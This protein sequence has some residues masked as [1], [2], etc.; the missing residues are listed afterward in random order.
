MS[1]E[2]YISDPEALYGQLDEPHTDDA[3]V[4]LNGLKKNLGID[5]PQAG[6]REVNNAMSADIK[7][8]K[9]DEKE[10]GRRIV[11]LLR[12][13]PW[14]QPT[15][16]VDRDGDRV[17]SANLDIW[18]GNHLFDDHPNLFGITPREGAAFRGTIQTIAGT[19]EYQQLCEA[20][21]VEFTQ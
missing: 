12:Q 21:G 8:P 17:T 11:G 18:A 2:A 1:S 7:A 15:T 16:V 4:A 3:L 6:L 5:D 9:R 20:I 19:S 10:V 13:Y 14:L